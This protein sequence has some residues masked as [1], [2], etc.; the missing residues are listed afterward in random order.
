MQ[1]NPIPTKTKPPEITS[2]MFKK[3]ILA[4]LLSFASRANWINKSCGHP[5]KLF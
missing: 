2:L 1:I 5:L 3:K 4:E